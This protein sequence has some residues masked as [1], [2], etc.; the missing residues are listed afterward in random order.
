MKLYSF[1]IGLIFPS[2]LMELTPTDTAIFFTIIDAVLL[3]VVSIISGTTVSILTLYIRRE[4]FDE[5]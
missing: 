3:C 1:I 2:L 5:K 4:F